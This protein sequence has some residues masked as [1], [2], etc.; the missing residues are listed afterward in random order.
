MVF[1]VAELLPEYGA[2]LVL[3]A[4]ERD[5]EVLQTS[6]PVQL[7]VPSDTLPT[8]GVRQLE[9]IELHRLD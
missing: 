6:G 4:W 2:T 5:G 3:L 7:V 9:S 8:R 1:S